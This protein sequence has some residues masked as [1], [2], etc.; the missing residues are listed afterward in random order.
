M[1]TRS[2]RMDSHEDYSMD[3]LVGSG[4][5]VNDEEAT[6]ACQSRVPRIQCDRTL[7]HSMVRKWLLTLPH[8]SLRMDVASD[9]EQEDGEEDACHDSP[10]DGFCCAGVPPVPVIIDY[11]G[12]ASVCC[13]SLSQVPHLDQVG[14]MSLSA[15]SERQN[16]E[17]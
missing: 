10:L 5:V 15:A 13:L 9:E 2:F 14:S 17:Q 3:E 1:D 7:A 12:I 16:K 8:S 6:G 4:C 11:S